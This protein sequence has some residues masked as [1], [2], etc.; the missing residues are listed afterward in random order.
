[1]LGD[2]TFADAFGDPQVGLPDVFEQFGEIHPDDVFFLEQKLLKH[3]LMD[4]DY[5]PQMRS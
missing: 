3:R 4:R 1:V 2:A 5:L